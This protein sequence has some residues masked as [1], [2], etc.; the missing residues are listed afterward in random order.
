MNSQCKN[1][2]FLSPVETVWSDSDIRIIYYHAEQSFTEPKEIFENMKN[3]DF[4]L[5]FCISGGFQVQVLSDGRIREW[6]IAEGRCDLHCRQAGCRYKYIMPEAE[7][8]G[9]FITISYDRLT[10]LMAG[11]DFYRTLEDMVK[12]QQ[13]GSRVRAITPFMTSVISQIL[14]HSTVWENGHLFFLAKILELL[15][16]LMNP[17]HGV[18][19]ACIGD[20][21]LQIV[22]KAMAFLEDE[23]DDPPSVADLA[24]RV[25]ISA[26]KLKLLFPRAC[27]VTPYA[28]LRKVR[29]EKA[30]ALLNEGEM[31]VT[32]VAYDV[33]FSSI[34]HFAKVFVRYH[35][36]RPSQVRRQ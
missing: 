12:N 36:I 20:T 35:G 3:D 4:R 26:S 25:G 23:L 30:L 6:M 13:P 28:Y 32:E 17:K 1:C 27:G 8:R 14:S 19:C 29:M 11:D 2:R 24:G 33:G 22:N 7:S 15:C 10:N 16:S 34:S 9:L 21:D 18:N 5:F 31:N